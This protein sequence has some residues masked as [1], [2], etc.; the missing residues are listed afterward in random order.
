[1]RSLGVEHHIVS[2]DWSEGEGGGRGG[3]L[4]RKGKVQVAAREKRY[5]ALLNFCRKMDV[6]TLMVAHHLDDQNGQFSYSHILTNGE[7]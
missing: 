6:R 1:M 2:L 4:P 3:G 5:P 7:D